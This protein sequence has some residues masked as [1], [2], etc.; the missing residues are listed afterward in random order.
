V[1]AAAISVLACAGIVFYLRFLI[2]LRKEGRSSRTCY[3]LRLPFGM[4][5]DEMAGT[6]NLTARFL[7]MPERAS[8][9]L[10]LK[11]QV[12]PRKPHPSS[13]TSPHSQDALPSPGSGRGLVKL[14][15]ASRPRSYR[16]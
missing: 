9:T 2:A 6:G 10:R 4:I 16:W 1:V 14:G 7:A 13:G 15:A 5:G 12:L 8:G 3:V 11:I